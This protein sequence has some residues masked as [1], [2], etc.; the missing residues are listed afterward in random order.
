MIPYDLLSWTAVP[1]IQDLRL[2]LVPWA[3]AGR[4]WDGNRNAW[5][6]SAGVGIQRYMGPFGKGAYLRLDAA[7]PTG[8]DRSEDIRWYLRFSR[9]LF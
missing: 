6:S 3:D 2:Q 8:P 4:V 1:V 5:L 7:F 9:A